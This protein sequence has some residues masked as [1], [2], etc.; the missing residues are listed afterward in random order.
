MAGYFLYS[1]LQAPFEKF[2]ASPT[3][4]QI[5][6]LLQAIA[7]EY[8]R[9]DGEAMDEEDEGH[10]W[11]DEDEA[12]SLVRSRLAQKNWYS[13]LSEQAAEIF[14]FAISALVHNAKEFGFR[15]EADPVYW[16]V[17]EL[18]AASASENG[19]EIATDCLSRFGSRPYRFELDESNEET[20]QEWM[21]YH[22]MHFQDEVIKM[23]HAVQGAEATVD[24]SDQSD[25][26][27]EYADVLLPMLEKLSQEPRIL[28]VETDT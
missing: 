2:A 26:A 3:D 13:G 22:G 5:D 25:A 7:R 21:P 4:K 27:S 6:A 15:V 17:I 11:V 1:I 12:K 20:L 24:E 19:E 10:G 16:D 23:L 9:L 28:L 14:S 8:D 18:C